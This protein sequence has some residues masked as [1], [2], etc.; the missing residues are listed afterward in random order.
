MSPPDIQYKWV[1]ILIFEFKSGRKALMMIQIIVENNSYIF[2]LAFDGM[3]KS[4]N[5]YQG[6][7]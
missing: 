3:E 7:I 4:R 6:I 5:G 1:P 2:V